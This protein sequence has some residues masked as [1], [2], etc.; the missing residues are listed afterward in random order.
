VRT[1]PTGEVIIHLKI[2]ESEISFYFLQLVKRLGMAGAPTAEA[3]ENASV[4]AANGR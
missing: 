3:N 1:H 4:F 2:S